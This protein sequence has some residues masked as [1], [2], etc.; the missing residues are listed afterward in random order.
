MQP[1]FKK[2]KAAF[3]NNGAF[4][5]QMKGPLEMLGLNYQYKYAGEVSYGLSLWQ[6]S[7]YIIRGGKIYVITMTTVMINIQ[8]RKDNLCVITMAI[9]MMNI[10]WR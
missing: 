8:S 9:V 4:V 7:R 2:D 5:V 10:Q 3:A 1:D 6:P